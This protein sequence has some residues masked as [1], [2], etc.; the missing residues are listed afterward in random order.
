MQKSTSQGQKGEAA[1]HRAWIQL[2]LLLIPLALWLRLPALFVLSA[3]LLTVVPLAWWWNRRSLT[4]VTYKR[5]LSEK[6]AFPGEVIELRL[7]LANEKLLPLAWLSLEDRWSLAL[8]LVEGSLFPS[9]VGQ[10]GLFR[11]AFAVRWYER[12][13]RHYQ[14]RCTRRGFYPFG[15]SWGGPMP[16]TPCI[17]QPGARI[18]A[19]H[20]CRTRIT[21]E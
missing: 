20:C 9:V 15:Q 7:R 10:M 12:V 2:A 1:F 13:T 5:V 17:A 8:P 19:L 16:P 14:L 18:K 3:F 11:T 6:R 4:G 21:V